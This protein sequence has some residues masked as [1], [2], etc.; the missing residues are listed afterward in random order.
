MRTW[1]QLRLL[2]QQ[3]FPDLSPDL[4]D[5]YLNTRYADVVDR[6][7]WKGLEVETVLQTTAAYNTG[8][9]SVTQGL[10]T[11]TGAGTAFTLAMSGMKFELLGDN[12]I[13]TFT[14]VSATSGTLDRNYEGSTNPAGGF[15]I[16]Q[17]EYSL[18][19]ATKTVISVVNPLTALPLEDLTKGQILR[20]TFIPACPGTPEAFALAAD[21]N[22]STPPVYHTLQF[23]PPPLFSKGYPLRYT[24]A[25]AGFSGTNTAAAPLPWVTDNVLLCGCRADGKHRLKDYTGAEAQEAKY[26]KAIQTMIYTDVQR[27]GTAAPVTA[28]VFSN[29]RMRRVFR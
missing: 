21:T 23:Y 20:P 27:R 9:V 25:T 26:E 2:V 18:P 12:A 22:E 10:N 13:Y 19:A 5:G 24:K 4:L 8:S 17:D 16:F 14:Y 29:Y 11:V 15:W 1:G 7:P 28:P 3:E 6:W